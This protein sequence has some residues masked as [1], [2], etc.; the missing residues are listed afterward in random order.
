ML[1]IFS[2]TKKQKCWNVFRI[3]ERLNKVSKKF[4]I[5]RDVYRIFFA[6]P[7]LLKQQNWSFEMSAKVNRSWK[8]TSF[9]P[10]HLKSCWQSFEFWQNLRDSSQRLGTGQRISFIMSMTNH[11]YTIWLGSYFYTEVLFSSNF[12]WQYS[13][14][15][16]MRH[17]TILIFL[18]IQI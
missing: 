11:F 8:P 14:K 12:Y 1:L 16:I 4:T 2:W 7:N 17:I 9:N 13:Y 6:K 18:S 10:K 15:Q 5:S 3:Q